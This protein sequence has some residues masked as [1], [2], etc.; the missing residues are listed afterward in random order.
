M[1]LFIDLLILQYRTN[2]FMKWRVKN[3]SQLIN[4]C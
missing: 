1:S 3:L 4:Q 2:Y